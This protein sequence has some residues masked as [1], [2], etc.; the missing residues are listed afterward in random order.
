MEAAVTTVKGTTGL[1][2][3][4]CSVPNQP[5]GGGWGV[6]RSLGQEAAALG[7]PTCIMGSRD[8][9]HLHHKTEMTWRDNGSGRTTYYEVL[10]TRTIVWRVL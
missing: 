5:G 7:V 6:R 3:R 1:Y 8:P 2:L 4:C 9:A 10:H